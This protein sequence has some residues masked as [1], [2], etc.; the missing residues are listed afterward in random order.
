MRITIAL[1][2]MLIGG[3]VYSQNTRTL[4]GQ[5]TDGNQ[6]PVVGA[7]VHILNTNLGTATDQEGKFEIDNLAIGKYSIEITA[8][9]FASIRQD[10]VV[11]ESTEALDIQL[12]EAYMQL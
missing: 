8:V 9:G 2:L 7:N 6:R 11:G 5:I 3:T 4:S 10:V 12:R 1:L